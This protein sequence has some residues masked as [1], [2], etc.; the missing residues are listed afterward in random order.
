MMTFWTP[1]MRQGTSWIAPIKI[2][3]QEIIFK[4]DTGA[5][6]T[7][8]LIK[9]FKTLPNIKLQKSAKVLCGPN[10]QPL[11]IMGQATVQCTYN[12]KTSNRLSM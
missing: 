4:L 1:S 8:V 12:G 6:A 10:N 3:S 11:K 5:K 9:T 2:N 7:A